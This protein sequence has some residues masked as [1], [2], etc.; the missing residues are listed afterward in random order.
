[1]PGRRDAEIDRTPY[2]VLLRGPEGSKPLGVIWR[3][4]AE[5][6]DYPRAKPVILGLLRSP[7]EPRV[8]VV[9]MQ[10][11]VGTEAVEAT[12]VTVMGGR[13]DRGWRKE[14]P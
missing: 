9:A 3:G 6:G 14:A 11:V 5:P 7:F 13:L 8:A 4:A 12:A 10:K 1:V 2:R